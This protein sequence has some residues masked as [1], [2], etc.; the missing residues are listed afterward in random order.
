VPSR[1]GSRESY[2]ISDD[3]EQQELEQE[4]LHV[5]AR[6]RDPMTQRVLDEIGVGA[7]WSCCDVGSG[8]G[9][10]ARWL[11]ERVGPTGRVV[12]LDVDTRFQP[13]SHGIVEVRRHDV[14]HEPIGDAEYDL[15]HARALLQHLD[16]RERVLDD[17]VRAARPGGWVVV[18]DSDWIQFDDQPVPEPFATLSRV[19]RAHSAAAHGHD[20]AWGRRLLAAFQRRGMRDVHADGVV[21]T[22]HGGTD[23]AEWYVAGLARSI[24]MHRRAGTLPADFP[25]D[26]AIAQARHPDFAILSPISVTVRGRRGE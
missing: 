17:M 24:E 5:L 11:A 14:V 19:L 9:T 21:Y 3:A 2:R 8:A 10:I 23:S 26:D 12:S 18:T 13:A 6:A 4:R 20:A 7:G 16:Q 22:M 15:I 25:A 1:E